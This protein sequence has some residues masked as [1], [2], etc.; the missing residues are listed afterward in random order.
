MT[1]E[2]DGASSRPLRPPSA[3]LY[4]HLNLWFRQATEEE[5]EAALEAHAFNRRNYDGL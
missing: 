5:I 2:D 4:E 3:L 1:P